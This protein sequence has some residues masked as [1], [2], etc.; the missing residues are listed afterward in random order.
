MTIVLHPLRNIDLTYGISM[1]CPDGRTRRCWPILAAWLADHAEHCN[2]HN[3]KYNLCPKCEITWKDLGSYVDLGSYIGC[4]ESKYHRAQNE[5]EDKMDRYEC[6]KG[7]QNPTGHQ[8]REIS[9]IEAWFDE[10]GLRPLRNP[11]WR[12]PHVEAADLHK[13]D[14]LHV[15]YLGILK[16]LMEWIHPFLQEFRRL[17]A[18]DGSWEHMPPYPAFTC[19]RRAYR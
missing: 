9:T 12:L 16:H 18:F 13:L 5:Y 4:P 17:E 10:R 3:T 14:M 1:P 6:L 2:L 11:F 15:V 8:R 7:R 19:P